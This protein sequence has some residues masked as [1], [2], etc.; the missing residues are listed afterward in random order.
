MYLP[1]TINLQKDQT[2]NKDYGIEHI[3]KLLEEELAQLKSLKAQKPRETLP[4]LKPKNENSAEVE[5]IVDYKKRVEE[6][7]SGD[8]HTRDR[9]SDH[10]AFIGPFSEAYR[11]YS[12]DR[13]V[14]GKGEVPFFKVNSD[15]TS[16][17]YRLPK[18]TDLQ[19][20]KTTNYVNYQIQ[21]PATQNSRRTERS[22]RLSGKL[23]RSQAKLRIDSV[24]SDSEQDDITDSLKVQYCTITARDSFEQ[25]KDEK[26]IK[27]EINDHKPEKKTFH[28]ACTR[29]P[30][31]YQPIRNED[32]ECS[33]CASSLYIHRR[34]SQSHTLKSRRSTRLITTAEKPFLPQIKQ[35]IP[36]KKEIA[37]K[38][39]EKCRKRFEQAEQNK[40][41]LALISS[42][43]K[44]ERTSNSIQR[45]AKSRPS[46]K[47]TTQES[48]E[49]EQ[50]A[51]DKLPVFE[52]TA[53]MHVDG[54]LSLLPGAFILHDNDY[55]VWSR[56]T[57]SKTSTRQK[58]VTD[59]SFPRLVQ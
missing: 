32:R 56:K 10:K 19:A 14:T 46:T 3:N 47:E 1:K 8:S 18:L 22:K 40:T 9:L 45:K 58:L 20:P 23:V 54:S 7:K 41:S 29:D 17:S 59:S 30:S 34:C 26:F 5:G 28:L 31:K 27:R 15:R 4:V 39:C 44:R 49:T 16:L 11:D 12:K 53:Y 36:V 48:T 55:N 52:C 43:R 6:T 42:Q 35:E 57:G 38:E 33:F 21:T 24:P 25:Q 50:K 2:N 37:P 13:R 51:V